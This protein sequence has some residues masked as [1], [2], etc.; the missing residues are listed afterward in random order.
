MRIYATTLTR[1]YMKHWTEFRTAFYVAQGGSVSSAAKALDIHRAT[2]LRHLDVVEQEL[3]TKVFLRDQQGYKLT[4][5]GKDLL[6]VAKLTEEQ[7][8]QFSRRSQ[9]TEGE[10]DG[11]FIVT[12]LD[13]LTSLLIPALKSFRNAHPKVRTR[14]LTGSNLVK[15]EY[16]QAHMA[17]RTGPKPTDDNYVV[18]PFHSLKIGLFASESYLKD[19]GVPLS[20]KNLSAHRF[21]ALDDAPQR[22]DIQKWFT[23]Y[24]PKD[25]IAYTSNSRELLERGVVDGMGIGFFVTHEAVRYPQLRQVLPSIT[26]DVPNWIL[27]HGDLHRSTKVQAFLEVLKSDHYRAQVQRL[28]DWEPPSAF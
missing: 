25:C 9:G 8:S 24:V 11:E 10:V 23:E 26:W 28:L 20:E 1:L 2:V 3:G 13:A 21:L 19:F 27:T 15:L 17:I 18:L 16:G 7:L 12:S 14:C 5:V 4:E 22:L 6:R